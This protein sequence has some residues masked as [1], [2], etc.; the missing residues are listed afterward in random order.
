MGYDK[1]QLKEP[2]KLLYGFGDKRIEPAGVITLPVSFGTAQNPRTKYRTF[3]MVDMFY[4]YNASFGRGLLNTFEAALHSGYLCL[5][6]PTTFGI[7][8]IFGIQKGV[9]QHEQVEYFSK[10]EASVEFK[11]A[12]E[13]EGDFKKM[14]LD[15]RVSDRAVCLCTEMSPH[16]QAK[17]L[18]FLDKKNDVFAWSTSNL[19]GGKHR[20]N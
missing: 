4:P 5:K 11:K 3:G 7:I 19:V 12:I 14:A 2:T 16:E 9:E 17:I 15:P 8:T 6:I 13:A 20:G 1:K 18:Q 10:K